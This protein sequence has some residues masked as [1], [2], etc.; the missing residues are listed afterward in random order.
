MCD[1]RLGLLE[2]GSVSIKDG[3]VDDLLLVSELSVDW[4]RGSDIRCVAVVFRSHVEETHV[5]VIEL[6][7]VWSICV[8]VMENSTIFSTCSNAGVG[9][10]TA[11]SVVVGNVTEQAEK[12]A[13]LRVFGCFN[14]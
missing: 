2:N 13:F 11:A 8:S 5:S 4:K 7:G 1:T 6:L 3:V 9:E 14:F 12:D 10:M